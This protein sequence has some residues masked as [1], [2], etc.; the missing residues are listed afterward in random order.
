MQGRWTRAQEARLRETK[1][2]DG[3]SRPAR[4][5]RT[6]EERSAAT[7][8]ALLAAALRVI[9]R[10]GYARMTTTKIAE[11]AGMT[12][13]AL[14]HHFASRSDLVWAIIDRTMQALNFD[15][16]LTDVS[17]LPLRKRIEEIIHANWEVLSAKE[18]HAALQVWLGVVDDEALSSTVRDH[19]EANGLA[20]RQAWRGYFPEYAGDDEALSRLQRVV[21][22]TL[23]G[24][25]IR[26]LLVATD[27]VEKDLE[28]LSRMVL[29]ELQ[30]MAS[31][32]E[33]Q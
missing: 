3:S 24:L 27:D 21:V 32:Q 19:L 6:Q 8:E 18:Y 7:E 2:N 22:A 26:R 10:E 20:I 29:N 13:G 11:E 30:K 9:A 17:H 12:R 28:A 31:Q 16:D 14:Q 1:D 4:K 15:P 5:R 33:P 23:R 25:A